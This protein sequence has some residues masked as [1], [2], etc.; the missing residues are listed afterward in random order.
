M[1]LRTKG[2][3]RALA[4]AR[5]WEL[6][7][8]AIFTAILCLFGTRA[9]DPTPVQAEAGLDA[10]QVLRLMERQARAQERIAEAVERK[11]Q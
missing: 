6:I 2:Q 9:C 4:R 10:R 5:M 1:R 7:V 8:I 11:C 3:D